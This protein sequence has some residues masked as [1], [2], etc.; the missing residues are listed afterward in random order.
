MPWSLFYAVW[1]WV[2]VQPAKGT[3]QCFLPQRPK[4]YWQTEHW[5]WTI[6]QNPGLCETFTFLNTRCRAF[7]F[8]RSW[9][10]CAGQLRGLVV[11]VGQ[12]VLVRHTCTHYTDRRTLHVLS[13]CI[14]NTLHPAPPLNIV[15][16]IKSSPAKSSDM[17]AIPQETGPSG[18]SLFSFT[19]EGNNVSALFIWS[20]HSCFTHVQ[21]TFSFCYILTSVSLGMCFECT[22]Y[23]LV[24]MG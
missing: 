14:K 3:A 6:L 18:S 10:I 19:W 16:G 22:L 23:L 1:L 9:N 7:Y 2:I 17:S 8:I 4:P 11:I 15:T 12:R 20:V 13:C 5:Y 21:N 24:I